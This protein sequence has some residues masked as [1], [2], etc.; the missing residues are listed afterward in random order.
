MRQSSTGFAY[1]F[2]YRIQIYSFAA[3]FAAKFIANLALFL[4]HAAKFNAQKFHADAR[5]LLV[6]YY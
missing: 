3:K 4:S 1:K 5:F 2:A 6:G